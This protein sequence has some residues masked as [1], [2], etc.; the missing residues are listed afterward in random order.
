MKHRAGLIIILVLV[1][2]GPTT[3]HGQD[4]TL[5]DFE[6][7]DQFGRVHS[8][9]D[10]INRVVVVIGSDKDGSQFNGIWDEAIHDSLE[11]HPEYGR[12]AFLALAD[13]RG[14]PFFIKGIVKG[15]FPKERDKWVLLD[16]KG[17]FTKAY[18]FD[19]GST[20]ILVF[21]PGGR[22]MH[23]VHGRGLEVDVLR[24]IVTTVRD[25]LDG[26]P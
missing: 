1:L 6:I 17:R 23:R 4:S 8:H 11:N 3:T 19:P 16:W 20:N 21:A 25:V 24:G 13:V 22:L 12:I 14:V 18:R 9:Q 2:V 5:I 26:Q 10:Y 15:K 7:K